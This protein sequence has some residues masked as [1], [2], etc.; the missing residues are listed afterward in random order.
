MSPYRTSSTP[1]ASAKR[2][3]EAAVGLSP[4]AAVGLSP[5]A[6]APK[7]PE[8]ANM[9]WQSAREYF[10]TPLTSIY[11]ESEAN[12]M[13]WRWFERRT[14]GTRL[15]WV[16]HRKQSIRTSL[17]RQLRLDLEQLLDLRP[18]AYVLDEAWFLNRKYALRGAVLVPRPETEELVE[19]ILQRESAASL[20]HVLDVGCGSGAMA[21]TLSLERPKWKVRGMD[22]DPRALAVAR[23]NARLLRAPVRILQWDMRAARWPSWDLVVCN[24][25]YIG[26]GMEH[27][28][29][30]GVAQ[31]EP[32]LALFAPE[33]DPL[34]YYKVL[35]NQLRQA[36][37]TALNASIP[38]K[39][40]KK[41][42]HPPLDSADTTRDTVEP[43]QRKTMYLEMPSDCATSIR[44][45]FGEWNTEIRADAQGVDRMLRVEGVR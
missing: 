1:E 33:A 37:N 45:L 7:T 36:M 27:T 22:I 17:Y 18:L 39:K 41:G 9:S 2:R 19:W 34:Y 40:Y 23:L 43:P 31:H 20:H 4:E 6:A 24:P 15:D 14:D 42:S 5:E 3:P 10:M 11:G 12:A 21:C 26:Q 30:P 29:S 35:A 25:P 8:A 38:A 32:Q 13:W 44:A 16:S 28:M